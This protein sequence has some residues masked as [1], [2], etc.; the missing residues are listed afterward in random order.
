MQ[1]D[2][3]CHPATPKLQMPEWPEEDREGYESAHW[4]ETKTLPLTAAKQLQSRCRHPA[5]SAQS[6]NYEH[7]E[8][9]TG[10]SPGHTA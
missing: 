9:L 2:H 7:L 10:S 1:I 8:N 6:E 5:V 3:A 4:G